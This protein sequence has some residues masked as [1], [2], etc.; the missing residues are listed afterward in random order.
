MSSN[1]VQ[2]RPKRGP[3]SSFGSWDR[4]R[5]QPVPALPPLFDDAVDLS[6]DEW[7]GGGRLGCSA[8]RPQ[9]P[10]SWGLTRCL[11][12]PHYLTMLF[13][14]VWASFPFGL[15]F[16]L[17]CRF[18]VFWAD[19]HTF[20][21]VGASAKGRKKTR[22]LASSAHISSECIHHIFI[23]TQPDMTRSMFHGTPPARK[24]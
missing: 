15:C 19:T 23:Y 7:A 16:D 22:L 13:E 4:L 2:T 11:R 12:S 9:S 14:A 6:S 17:V 1:D 21:C 5:T 18:V 8:L 3:W 10:E 20:F 24:P